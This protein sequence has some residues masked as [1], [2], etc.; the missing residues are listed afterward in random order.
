MSLLPRMVARGCMAGP[1]G[2][3]FSKRFIW[4]QMR[5]EV[6]SLPLALMAPLSVACLLASAGVANAQAAGNSIAPPGGDKRFS[7]DVRGN[8]VYASNVAGGG[9]TLAAIRQLDPS[10]VTFASGA[11]LRFQLLSGR[12]VAF[13]TAS[14][15]ARRHVRNKILDGEDYQVSTGIGTRVGPCSGLVGGGYA[16][17]RSLTE[18]LALP[19]A[20]SITEQPSGSVSLSC[21]SGA[22][23][24][25]IQGSAGKLHYKD[26][27]QGF[28]D[29]VTKGGSLSVGYRNSTLGDISLLTQYSRVDYS[30]NALSIPT[31]ITG[32]S[33]DFEQYGVGLQYARK[34]G[35]RLSGTAAV[36]A[37]Q[38]HGSASKSSGVNANATL[39]YR[40]SPRIQL[41]LGYD[42]GNQASVLVNTSYLHSQ[43]A[44]FKI[45]YRLS[46][47]ISLNASVRGAR[48]QYRGGVPVPLQ[49]RD[50]KQL[51]GSFGGTMKIGRN[52]QITLSAIHIERTADV[53]IY[54]FT[55]DNVTVGFA[56]QF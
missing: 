19:V 14:A 49:L 15:D 31:P 35:M 24:S 52:A 4:P 30:N 50:S 2:T 38:L 40:V 33:Q 48:D 17:R 20:T 23:I 9:D 21:G 55:S 29:S 54:D 56:T 11:T 6:L 10:D 28:V 12:N 47:R 36:L 41:D 26:K 37:T 3:D 39:T 44:D 32:V 5:D 51:L 42:R 1:S 45:N 34:I 8:A 43:S 16:R 46:Q 53:K 22:F 25:S 13:L 18:D 7:A 27:R